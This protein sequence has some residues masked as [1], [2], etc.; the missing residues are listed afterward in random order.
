MKTPKNRETTIKK[1]II[2]A[3]VAFGIFLISLF[4][5]GTYVGEKLYHKMNANI[6]KPIEKINS[7]ELSFHFNKYQKLNLHL[8]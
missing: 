4:I 7:E 3:I 1:L 8:I 5:I 2:S 6:E